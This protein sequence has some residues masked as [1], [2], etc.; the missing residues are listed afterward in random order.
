MSEIFDT[1]DIKNELSTNFIEYAVACNTDRAIPDARSGLKPVARRIFWGA[2]RDGFRSNKPH[3]KSARLVGNVMGSLHPHGESSIYLAM[4]RLSQDWILRYPLIDVHGNKGNIMGDGPAASRY[5]E[6]RLTKLAED[7][8]L[9]GLK[10]HNV[11]FMPNYD[12]TE[13]EPCT[14]PAIFPNLL[15]NPNKGIGVALACNFPSHNLREVGQAINDYLDGKEPMVLGPDFATGGEIINKNDIPQILRA[16]SGSVKI[17]GRYKIENNKIIFYEIPFETTVEGIIDDINECCEKKEIEGIE[18]AHDESDKKGLRIVITCTKG[19]N[20]EGVVNQLFSLTNLQSSFSYNMTALVGKT[21]TKLN[22][23]QCIEIYVNHNEDCIKREAEFD[24]HEAKDRLEIVKGLLKALEDIDNIIALIKASDNKQQ[25][26]DSLIKKYAFTERQAEAILAMRLSS[27]TKLDKVELNKE[28]AQLNDKIIDLSETIE[29]KEKRISILRQRLNA[30]VAKYGDERRTV[31]SQIEVPKKTKEEKQVETIVPK[32]V[33]VITSQS[34][35]IKKVPVNSFKTQKR[36]GKG[37]KNNDDI[38]MNI[39]KTNTVDS[40]LCFTNLG[41][42]YR[43]VVDNIPD[44]KGKPISSLV[45]LLPNEQV[46]AVSALRRES[47]PS[48]II[49]VTKN[50]IIKKS[51]LSEYLKLKKTTGIDAIKLKEGDS[52]A[53]VIFQNKEDIIIFTK[54]GIGLRMKSTDVGA[55]GRV[56]TGM[57][58]IKLKEGDEV[59]RVLPVHK[60]SDD[61]AIVHT[62]GQGKRIKMTELPVQNR[63]GVGLKLGN[64]IAGAEMVSDED[65][66]LIVGNNSSIGISVKDISVSSRDSQGVILIKNNIVRGVA[67]Y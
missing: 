43:I 62:N 61:I 51:N 63:G 55:T 58:G 14:L 67:K 56:T 15:C 52:V 36:N 34:G 39:S 47:I 16:G 20:P 30:L 29:K 1:N 35:L 25:A 64:P 10:K 7:G 8:L 27:L 60:E 22:F 59:V 9:T 28:E 31:L 17:R 48:F 41:K 19:V 33:V 23:K 54:M 46:I 37:V 40:M 50:G 42:M 66:L 53:N 38:I 26:K 45:Q 49:F 11:D 65:N 13:E 5:T 4:I 18:D 2:L 24:L 3:I 6:A 32:D 57:K 21:P 12:E 44:T